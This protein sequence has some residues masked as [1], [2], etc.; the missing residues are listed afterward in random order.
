MIETVDEYFLWSFTRKGNNTISIFNLD[1][2]IC[3]INL[4]EVVDIVIVLSDFCL[5]ESMVI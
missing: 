2:G 1:S 5:R 3:P 4:G